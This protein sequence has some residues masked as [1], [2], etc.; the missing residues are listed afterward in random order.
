V[1]EEEEEE[2]TNEQI[3]RIYNPD[4]QA[5]EQQVEEVQEDNTQEVEEF[6]GGEEPEKKFNPF[7]YVQHPKE[8]PKKDEHMVPDTR[9]PDLFNH[10]VKVDFAGIRQINIIGN[11]VLLALWMMPGDDNGNYKHQLDQ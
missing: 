9:V 7:H 3:M 11:S 10:Q 4:F 5:E 2:M 6:E 8:E 1:F